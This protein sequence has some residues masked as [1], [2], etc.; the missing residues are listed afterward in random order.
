MLPAF[1]NF[2]ATLDDEKMKE[3]YEEDTGSLNLSFNL[4]DPDWP[5]KYGA[6]VCSYMSSAM[7]KL[8]KSYHE[9]LQKQTS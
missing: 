9:W 5:T 4:S 1:D 6:S 3:I 2:L 8:L 7:I